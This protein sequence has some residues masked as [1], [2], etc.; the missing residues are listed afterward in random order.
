[1]KEHGK[2][3]MIIKLDSIE[4]ENG[5]YDDNGLTQRSTEKNNKKKRMQEL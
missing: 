5:V 3:E 4:E 1:M 2:K